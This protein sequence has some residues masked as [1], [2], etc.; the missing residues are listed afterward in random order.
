MALADDMLLELEARDA[1]DHQPAHPVVP[2][3]DRDLVAPPAQHLRRRQPAGARADDPDRLRQ[4][5]PRPRRLHPA[6]RPGII[7]DVALDRADRDA[8]EPLLDDAVALAKPVL[9]ADPAA[10]LGEV[11]G[12]GADLVRLLQPPLCRELQPVRD[13]V[14]AAGNGSSRTAR[15]TG[16]T[17]L[18]A[19]PRP[20]DRSRDRSPRSPRAARARRAWPAFP[21]SRGRIA[22]CDPA[23][24]PPTPHEARQVEGI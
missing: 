2:V 7:R 15:R 23:S 24:N 10:D 1:V 8:L 21:A 9:R 6:L 17:G 3:I 12:G 18:P 11:V 14:V 19:A 13:V 20:A 22:A 16:C 4:L 5:A